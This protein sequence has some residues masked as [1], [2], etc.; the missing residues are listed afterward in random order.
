M[1][2]FYRF[3]E[4]FYEIGY[5][6]KRLPYLLHVYKRIYLNSMATYPKKLNGLCVGVPSGDRVLFQ[7]PVDKEN[8]GFKQK[9]LHL[10]AIVAPK[11]DA[12]N[13]KDEKFG[14]A[15]REFLRTRLVGIFLAN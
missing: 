14:F 8:G 15:A 11:V 10:S 6:F 3:V 1:F 2:V 4:I 9:F 13:G 7:G 12:A 5:E